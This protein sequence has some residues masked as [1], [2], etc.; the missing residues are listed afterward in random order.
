M[1]IFLSPS[2]PPKPSLNIHLELS[3]C[4]SSQILFWIKYKG[5]NKITVNNTLAFLVALKAYTDLP[6]GWYVGYL[7]ADSVV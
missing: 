2:P 3:D 5:R 7:K 1:P 4:K 6:S